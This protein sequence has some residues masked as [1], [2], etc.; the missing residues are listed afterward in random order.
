M[1]RQAESADETRT[2][3]ALALPARLCDTGD[4]P[5][6]RALYVDCETTGLSFEHDQAIELA[7]LP[8]TYA[9]GDGRIGEVLHH[10]A[11]VHLH[12][13]A[14]PLD[15]LITALT[16]L[17]D[18][19]LRGRRIDAEAATALIAR[20]DLIIAH[21]ARFDRPFFERALPATRALPWGCSMRDVAWTAHG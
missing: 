16:G 3:R 17:T 9:P 11:Q 13:P 21:N 15:A 14:R 10:E 12:D 7:M 1:H 4:A 18:E 20:S 6:R 8:F 5:L 19:D 2:L